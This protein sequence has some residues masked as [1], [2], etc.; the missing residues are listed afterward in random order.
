MDDTCGVQPAVC[1]IN[2]LDLKELVV[3]NPEPP[4]SR[5][6]LVSMG[7]LCLLAKGN[8][9]E[10]IDTK[11]IQMKDCSAESF[12][13]DFNSSDDVISASIKS[14]L[15]PTSPCLKVST[16]VGLGPPQG[17]LMVPTLRTTHQMNHFNYVLALLLLYLHHQLKLMDVWIKGNELSS[18]LLVLRTPIQ[19]L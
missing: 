3:V 5:T 12:V 7:T 17:P 14:F 8:M 2:Q 10:L 18:L 13:S 1:Q 4:G 15:A 9:F 11:K 6:L 16:L 19:Q